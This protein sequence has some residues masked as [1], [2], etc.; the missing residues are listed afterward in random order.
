MSVF[1][2]KII[3][4]ISMLID[5][6]SAILMSNGIIPYKF[7]TI[8]RGIGRMAF[9]IYAFLI[10][11]GWKYT[12]YKLKYF[13]N[14]LL[15]ACISHIPFT[16]AFD[17]INQYRS[18]LDLSEEIKNIWFINLQNFKF[19]DFYTLVIQILFIF[20][21]LYCFLKIITHKENIKKNYKYILII[22]FFIPIINLRINYIQISGQSLNVFYTLAF[23]IYA[24]YCYDKFIPITKR[25]FSEY[26]ILLPFIMPI[27]FLHMDYGIIGILFILILYIE[28]TQLKKVI[29]IFIWGIILY[30]QVD[31]KPIIRIYH[32]EWVFFVLV[33]SICIYF[34]NGKRGVKL[35]YIFYWFYPI[36]L[37][38]LGL[39][40]IFYSFFII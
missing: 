31:T 29:V 19:T 2:L 14:M 38:I 22:A 5:H 10:V 1:Y 15:F 23:G 36:H 17:F 12:K 39:F 30:L 32:W 6:T 25:H 27:M 24:M 7:E 3:A 40:S 9:P 13:F 28:N 21:I 8:L 34:Y 35:K 4:L 11:N 33:A 20:F 37:F 26:I 18:R 16:L